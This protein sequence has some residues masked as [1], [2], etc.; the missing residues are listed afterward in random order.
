M[1][2]A[3]K[4]IARLVAT[5]LVLPLAG[6]FGLSSGIRGRQAAF[7]DLSEALALL[8]GTAGVYLRFACL[9][10]LLPAC[11]DDTCIRFGTVFSHPETR[12]GRS[13]YV[14]NFCSIGRVTIEDDVLLASHVS[15]MNGFRQHGTDRLD[16]PVRE[17]PGV[18]DPVTIGQDTW[19]GERAIVAASVGRHCIVGAGAVVMAEVPDYAIVVGVPARVVGDRRQRATQQ[20]PP[21][22]ATE[23]D[24]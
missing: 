23:S 11:G 5:V 8:P 9:R 12:I 16:V 10:L 17:Q 1:K 6:W 2:R 24:G 3:C 18:F 13:V 14:G 4:W 22:G 15:V 7:Q 20:N 21:D 19:V